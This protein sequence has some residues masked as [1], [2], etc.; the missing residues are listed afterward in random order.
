LMVEPGLHDT[1]IIRLGPEID[2]YNLVKLVEIIK[3]R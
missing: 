1:Y 3:R 2:R